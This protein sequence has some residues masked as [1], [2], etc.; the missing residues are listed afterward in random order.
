MIKYTEKTRGK[1]GDWIKKEYEAFRKLIDVDKATLSYGVGDIEHFKKSETVILL[2]PIF[3]RQIDSKFILYPDEINKR[4]AIASGQHKVS[5]ITLRLRD[6]LMRELASNRQ[7]PEIG[8]EKLYYMLAEKWMKESRKKKVKEY[9]EKALETVI[10][11]G[12]LERYEIVQGRTGA[13]K[14]VFTLNM[15][16]E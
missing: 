6:Y 9:T 14:V 1:K 3:R 13:D 12:L 15:E 4:T 11:L 10:N 5:S 16:W 2:N 8:V 7:K